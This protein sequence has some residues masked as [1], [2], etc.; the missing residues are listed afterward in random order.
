MVESGRW[1][2]AMQPL[3]W[4]TFACEEAPIHERKRAEEALRESETRFRLLTEL[5]SDYA[6]ELRIR[7][8]GTPRG[9]WLTESF[10]SMFGYSLE[11]NQARGGLFSIVLPEDLPIATEHFQ[12]GGRKGGRDGNAFS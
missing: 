2:A 1:F 3:P 9:E 6:Y 5:V 4:R 12:R 11:E 10:T 8:D 7:P